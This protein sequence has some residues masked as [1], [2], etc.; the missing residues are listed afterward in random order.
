[1]ISSA[2]LVGFIPGSEAVVFL[3]V[4]SRVGVANGFLR[5]LSPYFSLNK[6]VVEL[7]SSSSGLIDF[8]FV[9][10]D[11]PQPSFSKY[12]STTAQRDRNI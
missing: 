2:I 6:S 3:G 11:H 5:L 8:G 9:W 12:D 1:M 10:L 4:M 7:M